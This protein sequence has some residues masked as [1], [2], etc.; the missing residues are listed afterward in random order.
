MKKFK[1]SEEFA[2]GKNNIGYVS[3]DFLREY[4]NEE[5][6]LG[7]M[8]KFDKLKRD[9]KDSEIIKEFTVEECTL[10]NVLALIQN[11]LEVTMDGY[12]NI[13]Y[14]KGHPS[15]VVR[16]YWGGGEWVVDVWYRDG[17]T[18]SEG[19]RVFSPATGT[20]T[21]STVSSDPLADFC[22]CERCPKCKKIIEVL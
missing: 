15:R 11:R 7:S 8:L 9:M 17:L 18:W 12:A 21:P 16:V 3:D 2:K 14:I 20:L 4:G 6:E 22:K 1:V 19:I 13:F 10:G 5:F